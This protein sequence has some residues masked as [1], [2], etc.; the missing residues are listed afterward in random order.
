MLATTIGKNGRSVRSMNPLDNEQIFQV[1]P[2]IFAQEPHESRS[3]RYVYIPTIQVLEGLRKEGFLPFFAAQASSRIPGKSEFTKHMLRLRHVNDIANSE[4]ANEIILVN[5]HDGTSSYQL[6]AGFFRSVCQNGC[7]AGDKIEDFRVGHRGNIQN[8][9]IEAAY[10]IVDEFELV[11]ESRETMQ[12]IELSKP[13]QRLLAAA[14]LDLRFE[15]DEHGRSTAPVTPE[16][17]L[18]ANRREDDKNSLWLTFNRLQENLIRGGMRG[19]NHSGNRTTTREVQSVDSLIGVNRA[20]WTLAE[21]MAQ[22][23]NGMDIGNLAPAQ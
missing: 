7:I 5:S 13:E 9:V 20:L 22:L 11:D 4:G 23:K 3:E 17:A 18:W 14:S 2:S 8:D 10:R 16:R 19:R 6:L 21:G 1:A 12:A 15:R